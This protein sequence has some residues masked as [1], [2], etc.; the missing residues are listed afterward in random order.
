MALSYPIWL[1]YQISQVGHINHFGIVAGFS[2]AWPSTKLHSAHLGM[3]EIW[4]WHVNLI[5]CWE[6]ASNDW[7]MCEVSGT[8]TRCW[9]S[10][11]I[12]VEVCAVGELSAIHVF[13]LP[14]LWVQAI[15]YLL[16]G[17]TYFV[18]KVIEMFWY[19]LD[20]ILN[21]PGKAPCISQLGEFKW[22]SVHPKTKATGPLIVILFLVAVWGTIDCGV[23]FPYG[24]KAVPHVS[25]CPLPSLWFLQIVSFDFAFLPFPSSNAFIWAKAWITFIDDLYLLLIIGWKSMSPLFSSVWWHWISS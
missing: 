24:Y 1:E 11:S 25:A 4:P 17:V 19:S 23:P 21:I 7:F 2:L 9:L 14:Y 18:H 20:F 22:P 10:G 12:N 13:D 5:I 16:G 8:N 3:G 15:L 6:D